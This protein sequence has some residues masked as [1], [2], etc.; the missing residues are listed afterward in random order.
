MRQW[1][2][3]ISPKFILLFLV[4]MI[5][6]SNIAFANAS[7]NRWI[8]LKQSIYGQFLLD[9]QTIR[10]DLNNDIATYWVKYESSKNHDGIYEAKFLNHEM[11]DFR[12]KTVTKIGESKYINGSPTSETTQFESP[13]GRTFN[14]FPQD[15][16]AYQVALLC[17]RQPLYAKPLWKTLANNRSVGK[18]QLDVNNIEIDN[19]SCQ[20]IV[21]TIQYNNYYSYL[22]NFNRGTIARKDVYSR[23]F[24]PEKIPVPESVGEIIYNEAYYQYTLSQTNS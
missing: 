24:E 5:I 21:Y 7:D 2:K 11:I 20:A 4:F 9:K 15:E 16:E 6:C 22:C 13:E 17:G 23:D 12:N 10:Y 14:I 19:A 18:I 3:F 8:P 1:L